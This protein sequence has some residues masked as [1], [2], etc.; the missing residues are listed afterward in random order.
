MGIAIGT[1]EIESSSAY[2]VDAAND[3]SCGVI[4]LPRTYTDGEPTN[5]AYLEEGEHDNP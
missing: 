2:K 1:L 5:N 4:R 3:S